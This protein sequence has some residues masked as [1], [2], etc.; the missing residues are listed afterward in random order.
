[1]AGSPNDPGLNRRLR[2][3]YVMMAAWFVVL[4]GVVGVLAQSVAAGGLALGLFG[5]GFAG[6]VLLMGPEL[7]PSGGLEP[8]IQRLIRISTSVSAV[9]VIATMVLVGVHAAAV[10]T[11]ATGIVAAVASMGVAVWAAVR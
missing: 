6:A 5:L 3:G 8:A 11:L 4:A 7:I 1:M 2:I 10:L 9:L